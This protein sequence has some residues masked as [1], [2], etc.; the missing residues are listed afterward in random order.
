M[1]DAADP[2]PTGVPLLG[3]DVVHLPRLRAMIDGPAGPAFLNEAWT[4][5]EQDDCAGRPSSLAMTWAAKEATMKAL[6]TGISS[7]PLLDIEV[8][9]T[10]GAAPV[11]RLHRAAAERA[12]AIG[13]TALTL[14]ISQDADTAVAAV[15]GFGRP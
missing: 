6:G 9:R 11:L 12:E 8:V 10:P 14:S 7:V 13:L 15:F 5:Q 3:I 1:S 4:R 2:V